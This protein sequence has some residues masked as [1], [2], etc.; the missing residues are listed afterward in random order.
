MKYLNVYDTKNQYNAT[1]E[2][3]RFTNTSIEFCFIKFS[4]KF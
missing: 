4:V 2:R 1:D 3:K